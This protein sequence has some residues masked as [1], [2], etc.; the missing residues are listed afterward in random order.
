MPTLAAGLPDF[1]AGGAFAFMVLFSRAGAALLA[2]PGWGEADLPTT[3]RLAFAL[4]FTLLLLPVVSVGFPPAP[5]SPGA[6]LAILAAETGAGIFLGTAARLFALALPVAG[7]ITALS[8][9]ISNAIVFDPALA[10]QGGVL[11]RLFGLLAAVLIFATDL[12]QMPLAAIAGS[13]AV[14]PAGGA[15]PGGD[16]AQAITE[17]VAGGFTLAVQLSAPFLLAALVF[18][19]ALGLLARLVPSLQVFFV[20]LPVQV[21]GGLVLMAL[22]VGGVV[23]VWMTETRA[24]FTL[25][26]GL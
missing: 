19:A 3:V 14:F 21:L 7:Q 8:L 11:S 5:D 10:G 18:N 1:L 15:L 20:A 24:A 26:P 23:A 12:W 13:Y 16:L 17:A 9:G 4:A 6:T 2:S 25:L 22:L